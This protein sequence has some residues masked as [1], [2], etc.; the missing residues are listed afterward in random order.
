MKKL[1]ES[2]HIILPD[3]NMTYSY[4]HNAQK[5]TSRQFCIGVNRLIVEYIK[6][7][8]VLCKAKL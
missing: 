7:F 1:Q 2:A 6:S 8:S 5:Q 3:L 4:M